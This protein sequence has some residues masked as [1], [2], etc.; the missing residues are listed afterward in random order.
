MKKKI[1]ITGLFT[2]GLLSFAGAQPLHGPF[3]GK[4]HGCCCCCSQD[5]PDQRPPQ[6][7]EMPSFITDKL[8]KKLALTDEQVTK[9]KEEEKAF[10]EKMQQMRPNREDEEQFS[11]EVMREKMDAMMSEHDTAVK[12]ILTDE[13]YEKYQKYMKENRPKGPRNGGPGG[14]G[15]AD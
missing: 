4:P 12:K 14:P 13:Q 7:G 2:F 10:M 6:R 9:L 11:P 8:I 15:R 5:R 3:P 1:I